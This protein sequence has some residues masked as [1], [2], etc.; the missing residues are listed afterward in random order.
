[1]NKKMLLLP[2]ALSFSVL[3]AANLCCS[4]T[5]GGRTLGA[6]YSPCAFYRGQRAA[7]AAIGEIVP[8]AAEP[9]A[10]AVRLSLSFTP[11]EGTPR[12][13]S[14]AIMRESS[15]VM[16]TNGVY[17]GGKRLGSVANADALAARLERFITGQMP[18]WATRGEFSREVTVRREYTR[19]GYVATPDDM[20]LLIS[21]AAPVMYFN[22]E[23]YMSR[24]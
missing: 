5:L 19:A 8:G 23:G 12:T 13:L 20:A 21:G 18:N 15:D 4:V 16:L 3:S 17:V 11:P 9:P 24:A 22:E 14:A 10:A 6:R 1:M 7:A 2:L